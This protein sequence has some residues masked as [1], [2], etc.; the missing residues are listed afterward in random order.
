MQQTRFE[1]AIPAS[2][3]PQTYALEREATGMCQYML[4]SVSS[5]EAYRDSPQLHA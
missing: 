3:R 5:L 1:L 4:T 2:E